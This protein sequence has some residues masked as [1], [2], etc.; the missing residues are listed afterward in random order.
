MAFKTTG[1][2]I[3]TFSKYVDYYQNVLNLRDWRVEHSGHPA[4]RGAMAEVGIS[5]PDKLA[6]WSLGKSFGSIE[7]T[8]ETL[9]GTALHE[10]LHVFFKPLIEAALSRDEQAIETAEHSAIVVLEKLLSKVSA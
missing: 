7:V 9:K 3:A 10:L 8:D 2:N 5:Y 4:G 1:E 6:V